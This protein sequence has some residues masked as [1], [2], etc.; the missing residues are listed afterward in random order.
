[1]PAMMEKG[2]AIFK[3]LIVS[4][5]FENCSR[6]QRHRLVYDVLDDLFQQGLHALS[7]NAKTISE[8]STK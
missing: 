7:I 1:M 2:K 8:Y 4:S 6:I 3:L 5:R